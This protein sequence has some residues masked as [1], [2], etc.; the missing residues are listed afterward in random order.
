MDPTAGHSITFCL[1]YCRALV[2]VKP[3]LY[4]PETTDTIEET[5][6]DLSGIMAPSY[7]GF[8]PADWHD[9]C[10]QKCVINGKICAVV[11]SITS[12]VALKVCSDFMNADWSNGNHQNSLTEGQMKRI[13]RFC[14]YILDKIV[15][16]NDFSWKD[17]MVSFLGKCLISLTFILN[18]VISC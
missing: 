3:I 2:E 8:Q 17:T 7:H 1:W 4:V 18:R 6:H 11:L 15:I 13:S 16:E 12:A 9:S 14:I 10:I 5:L